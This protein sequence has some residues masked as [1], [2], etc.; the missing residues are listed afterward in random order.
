MICLITNTYM[1]S[2]RIVGKHSRDVLDFLYSISV[3]K[4]LGSD[5]SPTLHM[6]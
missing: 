3:S 4:N 2:M 1:H 5:I 6:L